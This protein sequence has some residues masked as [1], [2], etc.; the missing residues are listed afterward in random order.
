MNKK[1][2]QEISKRLELPIETRSQAVWNI[3]KEI[4]EL[5]DQNHKLMKRVDDLEFYNNELMWTAEQYYKLLK[6]NGIE[7]PVPDFVETVDACGAPR[8]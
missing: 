6:T 5:K 2:L 1:E 4:N 3:R 8:D 7:A